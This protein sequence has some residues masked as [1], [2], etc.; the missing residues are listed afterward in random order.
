[1]ENFK[2]EA[3]D[4]A[5]PSQPAVVVGFDKLP[6]V[7]G[8]FRT[9]FSQKEAMEA[10][11][12]EKLAPR[13]STSPGEKPGFL[14]DSKPGFK[15]G[16]VSLGIVIKSDVL[17]SA[18]AIEHE[19]AKLKN[20]RL[21]IKIL[22][23]EAGDVS[24]DDVKMAASSANPV[25]IAFK[26]YVSAP[27]RELAGRMGTEIAEFQIIY[28]VADFLKNKLDAL[29]PKEITTNIIGRATILKIFPNKT[30][31]K[32]QIV[33]GEIL[34]GILKRGA[35]FDIIRRGKKIGNG[36]IENLQQGK[37]NVAEIQKGTEF[38]ALVNAKISLAEKDELDL[39]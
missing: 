28:E 25:I 30:S 22:R 6:V 4:S 3:I 5:G 27:A 24:E 2:G 21:D 31:Q 9:F 29:A 37:L 39:F 33:G 26:V 16:D 20:D 35:D 18:E 36:K 17:G 8:E 15:E 1:M 38:G 34:D 19:M 12:K 32:G 11:R 10:A 23:A 13:S 7:G 14:G